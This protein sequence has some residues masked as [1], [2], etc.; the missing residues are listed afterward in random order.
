MDIDEMVEKNSEKAKAKAEKRKEKAKE[1]SAPSSS[2][3]AGAT[4]RVA[5]NQNN[6]LITRLSQAEEERIEEMN[7]NR[8]QKKYKEDSMSYKADLVRRFN[9]YGRDSAEQ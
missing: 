1:K 6:R 8:K 5:G 9:E 4:R 7:R 2:E 3:T